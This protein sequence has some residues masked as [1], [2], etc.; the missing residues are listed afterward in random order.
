MTSIQDK[1]A[2]IKKILKNKNKKK[3]MKTS[4]RDLADC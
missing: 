3:P 4:G 1:P 2:V